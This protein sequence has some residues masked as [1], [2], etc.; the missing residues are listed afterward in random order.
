MGDVTR[1]EGSARVLMQ[2]SLGALIVCTAASTLALTQGSVVKND[3][4]YF[5]ALVALIWT[6]VLQMRL[7]SA[8]EDGDKTIRLI[9]RTRT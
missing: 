3:A 9:K 1:D 2:I 5:P 6:L 7:P 8:A 4:W